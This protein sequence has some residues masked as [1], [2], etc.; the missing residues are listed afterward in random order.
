M[1]SDNI[2]QVQEERTSSDFHCVMW[3][4]SPRVDGGWMLKM[5]VDVD[6]DM[7]EVENEN[8]DEDETGTA[9]ER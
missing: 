5:D 9:P 8:E 2:L 1:P 4:V 3:Q 6:M 7:V